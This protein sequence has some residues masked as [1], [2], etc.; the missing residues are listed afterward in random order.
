MLEDRTIEM[1]R[2]PHGPLM[3]RIVAALVILASAMLVGC[4]PRPD[5]GDIQPLLEQSLR[6]DLQ[7]VHSVARAFGGAEGGAFMRALGAPEP[8]AVTV[9][10]VK[11]LE[12]RVLE[13]GDHEIELRYDIVIGG[14]RRIR[15][16]M[17]R[18]DR[19]GERWRLLP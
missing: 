13:N 6:E 19:I 4:A 5:A 15:E 17:V 10:N 8:A 7:D 16:D 9:E 18:I 14:E 3:P 11:I 1:M 2:T 12:S